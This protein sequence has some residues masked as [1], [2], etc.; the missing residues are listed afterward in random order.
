MLPSGSSRWQSYPAET[1]TSSGSKARNPLVVQLLVIAA[2]SLAVGDWRSAI[3]VTAMIVLSVGLS[4]TLDRRSTN[5]VEAL[6]KRVQSRALALRN[7]E[8]TEVRVA[9]VVPGDIVILHAGSIVPA[10]LRLLSTK[11]FF[12]SEAALTGE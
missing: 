12:V 2:V 6:G 11:D 8:E 9:D 10:D 4:F 5:A 7:G 3:V 1:M